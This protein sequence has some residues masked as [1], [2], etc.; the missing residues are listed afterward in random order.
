MDYIPLSKVYY[1]SPGEYEAEYQRRFESSFACH[2]PFEIGQSPLFFLQLPELYRTIIELHRLDQKI[3]QLRILLPKEAIRNFTLNSLIGEIVITN[4]FEGVSSSR[5]EVRESLEG[6]RQKQGKRRRFDGIVSKYQMLMSKKT[7][8]LDVP[9]D[10]RRLYDELLLEGKSEIESDSLPDGQLFRKDSVSV[11]DTF[12]REIHRGLY[13]EKRII[14]AMT[15]ALSVLKDERIDPVLSIGLFHYLFGYIHPFYDGNGRVS[16]FISSY[17]LARE[18]NPILAYRLSYPIFQNR[19]EYEE[20]FK[21]C[22]DPRNRGD[23]TPFLLMFTK[24]ITQAMQGLYEALD[25]RRVRLDFYHRK[26]EEA[27]QFLS[28]WDENLLD[29]LFILIQVS[30]FSEEGIGRQELSLSCGYSVSTLNKQLVKLRGLKLLVT[31]RRSREIHYRLDLQRLD[32]LLKQLPEPS[33]QLD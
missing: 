25:R 11:T 21:V 24:I 20:A 13:P 19:R 18:F 5:R 27:Q 9:E 4:E 26:I 22:N 23:A 3:D 32:E 33:N 8:P 28:D 12:D 10:I 31:E 14:Q 2:V 7:I 29:C 1:K 17:L 6:L 30:L 16:R 15:A